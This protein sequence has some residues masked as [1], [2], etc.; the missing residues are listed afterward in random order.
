ML[1]GFITSKHEP[2]FSTLAKIAT[3]LM[4]DGYSDSRGYFSYGSKDRILIYIFSE[5]VKNSVGKKTSVY[6][7]KDGVWHANLN[8]KRLSE[9]LRPL[10]PSYKKSPA[11][12][13]SK[14]SYLKEPQ[15]S[16]KF[17]E[18][19][20]NDTLISCIRLA[21]TT[22]GGLT[23]GIRKN[24]KGIAIKQE[25]YLKCANPNLCEGWEGILKRAGFNF[26]IIKDSNMWSGI[27]GVSTYSIEEIRKFREVG[28]FVKGVKISK[29]SRRFAGFEKN[30]M[31]NL[32]LRKRKFIS[33][34]EIYKYINK[35]GPVRAH[36]NERCEQSSA[37]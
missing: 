20:D 12:N 31:L 18:N 4:T 6:L 1:D 17:L 3:L 19:V 7:A 11:K 23:V 14:E 27:R 15:P 2:S 13:Q 37:W 24:K 10:S 29:K 36:S 34:K 22:D 5:L 32:M 26:K 16:V 35:K 25:L 9:S 33:T 30:I 28:G 21:L 8:N